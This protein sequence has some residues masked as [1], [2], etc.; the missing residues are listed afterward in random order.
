MFIGQKSGTIDNAHA[1]QTSPQA[2]ER[3]GG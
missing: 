1:A 2:Q 3:P